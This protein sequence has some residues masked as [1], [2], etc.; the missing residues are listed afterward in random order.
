MIKKEWRYLPAAFCEMG[1]FNLVTET[2]AATLNSFLQH[3]NTNSALV[4]TLS[5]TLEN[6]LLKLGVQGC[7]LHYNYNTW[8]GLATNS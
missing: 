6:L 4:T 2:T 5:V 7:P 8:G 3:Y 1:L